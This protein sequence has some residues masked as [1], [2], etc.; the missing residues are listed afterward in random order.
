MRLAADRHD[1]ALDASCDAVVYCRWRSSSINCLLSDAAPCCRCTMPPLTLA[2][3]RVW[4]PKWA[5]LPALRTGWSAEG[6]HDGKQAPLVLPRIAAVAVWMPPC[7]PCLVDWFVAPEQPCRSV[8]L[9]MR[10]P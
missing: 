1:V 2:I 9:Q 5:M 8:W 6:S 3:W 4:P 10:P 7:T